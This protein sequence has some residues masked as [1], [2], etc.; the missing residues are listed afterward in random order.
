MSRAAFAALV[1]PWWRPSIT[2]SWPGARF[3][4]NRPIAVRRVL[5]MPLVHRA[6]ERE[7]LLRRAGPLEAGGGDRRNLVLLLPLGRRHVE[8]LRLFVLLFLLTGPEVLAV[9]LRL[10]VERLRLGLA[11]RRGMGSSCS[12]DRQRLAGHLGAAVRRAGHDRSSGR[13]NGLRLRCG[14]RHPPCL[15][16]ATGGDRPVTDD[17]VHR[18]EDVRRRRVLV[19]ERLRPGDRVELPRLERSQDEGH[20]VGEPEVRARTE[21]ARA[22]RPADRP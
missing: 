10:G 7:L 11:P 22:N 15:H 8:Q 21:S 14:H 17:G 16:V 2:S 20:V 19:V 9:G 1:R 3:A 12:S 13:A 6:H 18:V 4:T 5:E